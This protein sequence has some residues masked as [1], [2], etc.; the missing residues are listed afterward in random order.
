MRLN[1]D[2]KWIL[3][4]PE[5]NQRIVL[6]L[7]LGIVFVDAYFLVVD[8]TGVVFLVLTGVVFLTAAGVFTITNADLV[9]DTLFLGAALVTATGFLT[10]AGA[11]VTAFLGFTG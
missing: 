8:F 6:I 11:A 9:V 1:I 7:W 3:G 10:V 5:K 2:E 4:K